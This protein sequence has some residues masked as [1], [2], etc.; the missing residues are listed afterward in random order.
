MARKRRP[1]RPGALSELAPLRILRKIV[2]LQACYYTAAIILIVFTALVAG[3]ELKLDL[4]LAWSTV[5]GD[6]T[7]GWMMAMIWILNALIR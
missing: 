1:P 6:S 2:I 5:R 7:M 3:R 4:L